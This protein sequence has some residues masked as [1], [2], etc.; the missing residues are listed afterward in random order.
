MTIRAGDRWRIAQIS[1]RR[2]VIMS[3]RKKLCSRCPKKRCKDCPELKKEVGVTR[4]SMSPGAEEVIVGK[5]QAQN[6]AR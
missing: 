2:G 3:K 5:Q 1:R 6:R 4:I